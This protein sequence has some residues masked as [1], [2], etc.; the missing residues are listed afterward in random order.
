[1]RPADYRPSIAAVICGFL[2]AALW[3]A[4]GHAQSLQLSVEQAHAKSQ[5][6]EILLV[7]IRSRTEW[8]ETG[9]ATNAKA[10]SMHERGFLEQ[11][12]NVVAG[13]RDAPIALI[14][15]SGGRSAFLQAQLKVRGFTAVYD[16]PAG[17]LGRDNMPGWIASGLPVV[18]TAP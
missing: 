1:M 8:N 15:A 6:G 2:L 10:I 16:V 3:V 13:D 11:L 4:S 18:Q 14:C 17:M 7:D 5:S 12:E 9:L